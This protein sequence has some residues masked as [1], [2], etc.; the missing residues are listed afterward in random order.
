MPLFLIDITHRQSFLGGCQPELRDRF[1]NQ[2]GK[3]K[4][5]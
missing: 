1:T 5:R 3:S 4:S 2:T